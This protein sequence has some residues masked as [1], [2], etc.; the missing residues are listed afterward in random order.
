MQKN[1]KSAVM[2]LALIFGGFVLESGILKSEQPAPIPCGTVGGQEPCSGH[3][4][5]NCDGCAF[6]TCQ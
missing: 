4:V 5:P 1:V 2:L 6:G 3:C